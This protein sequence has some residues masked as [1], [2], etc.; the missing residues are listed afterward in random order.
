MRN[1]FTT[2]ADS[3]ETRRHSN[4]DALPPNTVALSIWG[5]PARRRS[6]A[7]CMSWLTDTIIEG[8]ADCGEMT[9]PYLVDQ[10]ESQTS[11]DRP[12]PA[13]PWPL[14]HRQHPDEASPSPAATRPPAGGIVARLAGWLSPQRKRQDP[15]GFLRD[16]GVHPCQPDDVDRYL[17]RYLD[18]GGW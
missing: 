2:S 14:F 9:C 12:A 6:F 16:D 13:V 3:I 7:A 10:P 5:P 1:F 15:D 17:E 8:F 4:F 18:H 11:Y